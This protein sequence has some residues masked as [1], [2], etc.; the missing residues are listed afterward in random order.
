MEFG[1]LRFITGAGRIWVLSRNWYT[2][3]RCVLTAMR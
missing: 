1:G 2:A 3:W